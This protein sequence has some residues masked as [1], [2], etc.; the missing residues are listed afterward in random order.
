[1]ALHLNNNW[2]RLEWK[3]NGEDITKLLPSITHFEILDNNHSV[4]KWPVK[5]EEVANT[6]SEQG[7]GDSTIYTNTI[8]VGVSLRG[9]IDRLSD[10]PTVWIDLSESY[11][12]PF[13]RLILGFLVNNN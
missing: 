9:K 3:L 2:G 4:S 1:M 12:E 13:L 7:I 8:L 6:V 10:C 11:N 5:I